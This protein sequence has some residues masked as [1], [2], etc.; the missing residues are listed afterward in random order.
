MSTILQSVRDAINEQV[1][2]LES[3]S[4][5]LSEV[6]GSLHS[7]FYNDLDN[8]KIDLGDGISYTA[9]GIVTSTSEHEQLNDDFTTRCAR[10]STLIIEGVALTT[11]VSMSIAELLSKNDYQKV[12]VNDKPVSEVVD[13]D[14][15]YS[16]SGYKILPVDKVTLLHGT[17]EAMLPNIMS[18][19]LLR[20]RPIGFVG[21][22][23]GYS[24]G[25]YLGL[26]NSTAKFFA[27]RSAKMTNSNPV[28]LV[29]TDVDV[30]N[31]FADPHHGSDESHVLIFR[32]NIAPSQIQIIN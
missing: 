13:G 15:C 18:E 6:I 3:G 7:K 2:L 20:Y 28:I 24:D 8:S 17:S 21:I 5:K 25:V 22:D 16:I 27:N 26:F 11:D 23:D 31:L 10:Y 1:V 32:G 19:G 12:L 4:P 29:V 30:D 14:V 9:H